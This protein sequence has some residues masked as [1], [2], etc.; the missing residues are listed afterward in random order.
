MSNQDVFSVS[1]VNGEGSGR[2]GDKVR[3]TGSGGVPTPSYQSVGA[4]Q[5]AVL[6]LLAGEVGRTVDIG[7]DGVDFF[8]NSDKATGNL[9]EGVGGKGFCVA[10]GCGGT[11]LMKD[12]NDLTGRSM[13]SSDE[14]DLLACEKGDRIGPP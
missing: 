14:D 3:F 6:A 9:G 1:A 8:F 7:G 10:C 4:F 12:L 11:V 5:D 13:P 2:S